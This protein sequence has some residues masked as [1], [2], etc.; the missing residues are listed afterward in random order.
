[1]GCGQA[2]ADLQADFAYV[3]LYDRYWIKDSIGVMT[4]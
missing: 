4:E 3:Y 1:M 2:L